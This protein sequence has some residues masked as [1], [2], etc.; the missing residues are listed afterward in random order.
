MTEITI[1]NY[2]YLYLHSKIWEYA[3]GEIIS[4]RDLKSYLFEWR[5]PDKLRYLIIKE[6]IIL[7]LLEKSGK[8]HV[9]VRRPIF[10]EDN[11]NEYYYQMGIFE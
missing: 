2:Y 8:N 3:K 9:K 7:E 11:I 1:P 10:S 6:L 4:I 5:I